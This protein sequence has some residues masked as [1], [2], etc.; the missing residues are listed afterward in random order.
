MNDDRTPS[1]AAMR[2]AV[3]AGGLLRPGRPVVVLLSGGRDSTCLLHVATA[4]AGPQ[5]TLALHVNYGLRD[6]AAA[7]EALCRVSCDELGVQLAVHTP[8]ARSRGNL[9]A[10]ARDERYAAAMRL[11]EQHGAIVATGH[12]ASDQVET[13]LHRLAS[14]PGRR[15]LLGMDESSSRL[16]RPLLGFTRE[17]TGAYCR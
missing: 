1:A 13:V 4:V 3:A 16:V 10:W 8:A 14:S 11:A 9:Q 15:A 6:S 12:T 7:D 2:A 5:E 17:A